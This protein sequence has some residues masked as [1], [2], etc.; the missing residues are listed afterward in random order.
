[1][2]RMGLRVWLI[3]LMMTIAFGFYEA[4]KTALF[5]RM[6][7]IE[8]YIVTI[9][10]VSVLTF[11][12]ARYI[13]LKYQRLSAATER[14]NSLLQA[15]LEAMREGVLVVDSDG[16]VSMSNPALAEIFKLPEDRSRPL[17]LVDVT[18]DRAIHDAFHKAFIDKASSEHQVKISRP[19]PRVF[20][21]H[22][23]P[24]ISDSNNQTMG[25]VGV[26]FD[27]TK[28]ERLEQVRREFFSNL[29]HEL[30]T[31]LTSILAYVETL[32]DGAI[33]DPQNNIN[34]LKIIQKHALRMKE[35]ARDISDLSEVESGEVRLEL[36]EVELKTVVDDVLSLAAPQAEAANVTLVADVPQ[37]I[38]VVA[39]LHRLEQI[40]SNLVDNAIKFN[41]KGGTVRVS[42]SQTGNSVMISINDTGIGIAPTDCARIFERFY[43]VDK[44]RSREIGGSGL[45]L[46][47]VK[48]LVQAHGGQ[49]E[50]EST[51]NLG[52]T[53]KVTLLAPAPFSL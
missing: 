24:L 30:R 26:L 43:R 53:F 10:V 52:S 19:E 22:V 50:V 1:M 13:L 32:L 15:V 38:K 2:R 33:S 28:I 5:P 41:R 3:T 44:S 39:D 34:F 20:Q 47:I 36:K 6:T 46:A 42:A 18:R 9:A 21:L 27:I 16:M 48:H 17:R 4:I 25:A 14:T 40:L 51:P 8:S 11:I 31:P 12:T 45:G 49:I 35:L 7:V 23:T 29:S 37:G